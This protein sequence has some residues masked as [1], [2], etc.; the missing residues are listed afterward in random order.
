MKPQYS[1]LIQWSPED[2][3]YVVYVPDFEAHFRQPCTHGETY[4]EA[5]RQGK[6]VIESMTSWLQ[7]EGK[8]LPEPRNF[9]INRLTAIDK[10]A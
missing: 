10:V 9:A 6:D 2:S 5:A 7:E 1:I 3:C 8:S 4:E